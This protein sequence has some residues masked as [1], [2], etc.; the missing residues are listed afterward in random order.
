MPRLVRSI[1]IAAFIVLCA[2]FL[3]Q[4][5]GG[6]AQ[7][8]RPSVAPAD[9]APFVGDWLVSVSMESFQNA[10]LLSVKPDT[11]TVTATITSQG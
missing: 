10:F 4:A 9:A 8:P 2:S 1:V 6:D 5:I 7:T 3:V 11:G